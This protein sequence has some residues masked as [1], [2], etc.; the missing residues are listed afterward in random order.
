MPT[1]AEQERARAAHPI[2]MAA[3][4]A[5]EHRRHVE[6]TIKEWGCAVRVYAPTG[7]QMDAQSSPGSKYGRAD[8]FADCIYD[9]EGVKVPINGA[10]IAAQPAPVY[11][12][13]AKAVT[14]AIGS[15]EAMEGNSEADPSGDSS[16]D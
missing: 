15:I 13:L 8:M 1:K 10:D 11:A 16:S 12:T 6:V 2:V 4:Q 3:R 5:A 14:E 7:G 9:L